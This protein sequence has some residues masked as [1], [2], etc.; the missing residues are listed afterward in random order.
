MVQ[1]KHPKLKQKRQ[2]QNPQTS[3]T[4]GKEIQEKSKPKT[5]FPIKPTRHQQWKETD[6]SLIL[7]TLRWHSVHPPQMLTEMILPHKP[8]TSSFTSPESTEEASIPYMGS[9]VTLE[10]CKSAV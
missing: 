7:H 4:K 3:S 9:L 8:M 1:F 5:L 2:N 6:L 10:F